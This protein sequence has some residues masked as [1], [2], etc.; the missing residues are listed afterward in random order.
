MNV[1]ET[2]KIRFSFGQ[3]GVVF[4]FSIF[5]NFVNYRAMLS[6]AEAIIKNDY[7]ILKNSP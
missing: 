7:I 6:R 4:V 5:R 1:P 3:E 2:Q